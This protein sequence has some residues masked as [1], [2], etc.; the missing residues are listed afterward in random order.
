VLKYQAMHQIV[1]WT[2]FFQQELKIK[3]I[4]LTADLGILI[5]G[6]H[7]CHL[8]TARLTVG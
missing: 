7:C 3:K 6:D 2:L 1:V 4:L 5:S 8:M